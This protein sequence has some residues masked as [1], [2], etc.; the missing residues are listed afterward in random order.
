[1]K[2]PNI[3]ILLWNCRGYKNKKNEIKERINIYDI[4]ILTETKSNTANGIYFPGYKTITKESLGNSGGVAIAIKKEIEFETINYWNN[5]GDQIDIVGIRTKNLEKNFNLLGIYRRPNQNV[6]KREWERIIDF[7]SNN[8]EIMFAGDFNSHNTSWNCQD[9]DINGEHLFEA[10]D[11]HELICGN[12][13]TLSRLGNPGQASSNI[14][15][16]FCTTN[17]I[18][19]MEFSQ[20]QDTWN[21]DHFPIEGRIRT[22]INRYNRRSNRV[23]TKRTVWKYFTPVLQ[24]YTEKEPETIGK[25][26]S[27]ETNA[28]D[29][30][31]TF[32]DMLKKV[33]LRISGK[34]P[35]N[36][37]KENE[38]PRKHKDNTKNRGQPKEWWDQECKEAIEHRK[39]AL[40][41]FIKEKSLH[42]FI[43]F[44][45]YRAIALKTI[46]R[47]KEKVSIDSAHRLIDFRTYHM[48]GTECESIRI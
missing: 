29:K 33:T 22:S 5:I 37:D 8:L 32:E 42:S 27:N 31:K 20:V 14:D 23:S 30:F 6:N 43:E 41:T 11:E 16:F 36:M 46:N 12:Y 10:M 21:S 45:K 38:S 9:T 1:M 39:T 2:H 17:L 44:K 34:N 15:L 40:A 13:N 48:C 47:K 26:L 18:D 35:D 4:I 25:M 7:D 28:T 19:V 3:D 24:E